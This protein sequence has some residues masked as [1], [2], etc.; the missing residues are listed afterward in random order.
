MIRRRMKDFFC[1]AFPLFIVGAAVMFAMDKTG[2]LVL[3]KRLMAPLIIS[4]LSL[5]EEALEIF[6]LCFVRHEQGS[7]LLLKMARAGQLSY[8]NV[9]VCIIVASCS[10][11]CVNNAAAMIRKLR[12]K[13]ALPMIPIITAS[14]LLVAGSINWLLRS[15]MEA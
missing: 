10:I 9:I 4:F 15:I 1:E 5:P 7:A 13:Y 14:A 2:L 8:I 6:L 11:P 3:L 12:T